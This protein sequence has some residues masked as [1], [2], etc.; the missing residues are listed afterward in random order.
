MNKE[1]PELLKMNHFCR[2][3]KWDQSYK[4]QTKDKNPVKSDCTRI[5]RN[6]T[7]SGI[8]I[9]KTD[10]IKTKKLFHSSARSNPWY[11]EGQ[12]Q[13]VPENFFNEIVL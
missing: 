4:I 3:Q 5:V 13:C 11:Q 9:L 6:L 7:E 8:I 12:D 10:W 1:L 2:L